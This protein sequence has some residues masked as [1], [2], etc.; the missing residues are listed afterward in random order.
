VPLAQ[1]RFFFFVVLDVSETMAILP[2]KLPTVFSATKVLDIINFVHC[3]K[4]SWVDRHFAF[5]FLTA[6][7]EQ[8]I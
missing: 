2:L 8:Q 6:I 4:L 5:A 7:V 1:N 3:I